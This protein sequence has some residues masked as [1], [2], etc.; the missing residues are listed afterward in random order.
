MTSYF[1]GDGGRH[2]SLMGVWTKT[3]L[4][5]NLG[6]LTHVPFSLNV[7]SFSFFAISGAES[8]SCRYLWCY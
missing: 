3:K 7:Q 6:F 8:L 4:D 5:S 1:M 2:P